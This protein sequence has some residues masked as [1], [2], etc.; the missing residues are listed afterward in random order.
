MLFACSLVGYVVLAGVI[1]FLLF[2]WTRTREDL[3][4]ARRDTARAR[5][6]QEVARKAAQRAEDRCRQLAD[7]LDTSIAHTG[8]ALNAAAHIEIVSQ[9][10]RQLTDYIALEAGGPGR[11]A[12]PSASVPVA[13]TGQGRRCPNAARK[14]I[15]GS[16]VTTRR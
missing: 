10:L 5:T 6:R 14:A 4:A 3:Y 15:N 1:A 11:H 9:Q 2:R 7:Y 13:L 12:V 16:P 8:Q